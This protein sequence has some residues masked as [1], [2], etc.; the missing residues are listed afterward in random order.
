MLTTK[1]AYAIIRHR[2]N[3]KGWMEME[4]I[5]LQLKKILVGDYFNE[6]FD[7]NV[8]DLLMLTN[9]AYGKVN[10]GT[11][12]NIILTYNQYKETKSIDDI[13]NCKDAIIKLYNE[14]L[15]WEK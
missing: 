8:S 4:D 11:V 3:R 13:Y 15:N 6:N 10:A 14:S 9:H 2:R 12:K 7:K 5:K 1:N